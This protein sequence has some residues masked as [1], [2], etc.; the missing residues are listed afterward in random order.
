MLWCAK[1]AVRRTPASRLRE[2]RSR[3]TSRSRSRTSGQ[4]ANRWRKKWCARYSSQSLWER[5]DESEEVQEI[6]A[7]G[8]ADIV[9]SVAGGLR[10]TKAGNGASFG[11]GAGATADRTSE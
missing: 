11:T 2:N 8:A 6:N 4:A 9:R 1:H 7:L 3:L 5:A 10:A